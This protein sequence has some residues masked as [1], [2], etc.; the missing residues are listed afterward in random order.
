MFR[1][2]TFRINFATVQNLTTSAS[3]A[4][5]TAIEATAPPD[6]YVRI[7][8]TADTY[9]VVSDAGAPVT[10]TTSNGAVLPAGWV[11]YIRVP[12]N[13]IISVLQVTAAGIFSIAVVE[14]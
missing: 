11:D 7:A 6:P 1:E 10:C 4:N 9:F 3:H 5:S 2:N 14:P 13:S 8:A 12:P